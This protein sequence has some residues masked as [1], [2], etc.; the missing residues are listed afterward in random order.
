MTNGQR[1]IPA[2]DTSAARLPATRTVSAELTH[3]SHGSLMPAMIA[4]RPLT[5]TTDTSGT[6]SSACGRSCSKGPPAVNRGRE[7]LDRLFAG[8][9]PLTELPPLSVP[10][11]PAPAAEYDAIVRAAAS[12]DCF[13]IHADP[14][15]GEAVIAALARTLITATPASPSSPPRVLILTPCSATA[16]SL[17]ERL[18]NGGVPVVR[19]LADDEN[20][21]RNSPVVRSATPLA[22]GLAAAQRDYQEAISRLAEA[23]KRMAAFAPVAKAIARLH[24]VQIALTQHQA[25]RNECLARRQRVESD[26]RNE[27]DT[28]FATRCREWEKEHSERLHRL[29][30]ELQ[31]LQ[32]SYQEKTTQLHHIQQQLTEASRKPGLFARL[33]GSKPPPEV[34]APAELEKQRQTLEADRVVM[35]TRLAEL[36]AQLEAEQKAFPHQREQLVA[37]EITQRHAALDAEIATLDAH[38]NRAQSELAALQ[39]AIAETVPGDDPLLAEQEL[40]AARQQVAETTVAMQQVL[41]QLAA[42]TQ[43]V[44]ATP[45]ALDSDPFFTAWPSEV[46]FAWMIFDRAEELPEAEFVRLSRWAE[47]WIFVGDVA[48]ADQ[49]RPPPLRAP[50]RNGRF[51]E[52]S[53]VARLAAWLD[54][55]TWTCEHNQLV[56]RLWHVAPPRRLAITREPL[57]DRPEIELRFIDCEV[58]GEAILAEIAFPPAMDLPAA[59][60]FLF[61]TLGEVLLRPCGPVKWQQDA[62]AILAVWPVVDTVEGT[63]IELEPGIREKIVGTGPYAFTAAVRFDT[64]AGW[65]SEKAAAWLQA[66]LPSA[67]SSRF[68]ALPPSKA[69][70][71]VL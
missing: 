60:R 51:P 38:C 22:R 31:S 56:C 14:P 40:A 69:A 35:A 42:E 33:F 20:P 29:T 65:D 52:S 41:T 24:E 68:A 71:S 2:A 58:S 11:T 50:S 62:D 70:S 25:A 4:T 45:L 61:H 8:Q 44:V 13:L 63:W 49:L 57:A 48:A 17:T 28:P 43:V 3:E 9:Y 30:A 7:L 32:E 23:E 6:A 39:T 59:K 16:D 19:P 27:V 18:L 12:P 47:R 36:T 64:H 1:P 55:E 21:L 34:P 46:P 5:P 10:P 26:V 54:R 53:L 67:T 66:C 15:S 37:S